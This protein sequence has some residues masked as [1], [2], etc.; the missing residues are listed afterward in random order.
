MKLIDI[1]KTILKEEDTQGDAEMDQ[2][3]NGLLDSIKDKVEE[4]EKVLGEGTDSVLELV[5][6]HIES[7]N[8]RYNDEEL[9]F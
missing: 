9:P 4:L 7:K 6:Q 1:A 3:V 5:K 8:Q 2:Y